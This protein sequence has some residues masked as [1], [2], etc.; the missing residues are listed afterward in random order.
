MKR[1]LLTC[2]LLLLAVPAGAAEHVPTID[3]MLGLRWPGAAR[4]SPDGRAVAYEVQKANWDAN[5]FETEIWVAATDVG[6]NY[7]LTGGKGSARGARWSPDG[8]RLAF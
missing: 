6:R 7:R 2:G 3:E 5:A 8:K 1:I 4:V